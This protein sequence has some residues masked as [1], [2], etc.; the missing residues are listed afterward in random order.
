MYPAQAYTTLVVL[1]YFGET[2]G[3]GRDSGQRMSSP[4]SKSYLIAPIGKS[5]QFQDNKD[6]SRG[7]Q[8]FAGEA[9]RIWL[10]DYKDLPTGAKRIF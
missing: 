4:V 6:L 2:S 3:G 7:V 10:S 1:V 9:N 8:G 5:L